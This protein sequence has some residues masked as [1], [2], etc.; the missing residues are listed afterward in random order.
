MVSGNIF[1][2]EVFLLDLKNNFARKIIWRNQLRQFLEHPT[3]RGAPPGEEAKGG[4]RT[5]WRPARRLEG[6][7]RAAFGRPGRLQQWGIGL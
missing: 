4:A 5:S 1:A 7:G 6:P 2:E 3:R